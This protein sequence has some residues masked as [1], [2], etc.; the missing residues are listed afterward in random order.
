MLLKTDGQYFP[1]KPT[2]S[3][4]D[5]KRV[6]QLET[7]YLKRYIYMQLDYRYFCATDRKYY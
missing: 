3:W 5:I 6:Y 7:L 2:Y 1:A 4:I